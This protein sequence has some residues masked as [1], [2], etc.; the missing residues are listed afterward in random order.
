MIVLLI[1]IFVYMPL[2]FAFDDEIVNN[3]INIIQ[4][5]HGT[6]REKKHTHK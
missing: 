1:C 3:W 6:Q 2:D 4:I 5:V